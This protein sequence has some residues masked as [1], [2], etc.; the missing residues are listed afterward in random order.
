LNTRHAISL[1]AEQRSWL[2]ILIKFLGCLLQAVACSIEIGVRFQGKDDEISGLQWLNDDMQIL[3]AAAD[4]S[5]SL[6]QKLV[7]GVQVVQHDPL[8]GE[9]E[10]VGVIVQGTFELDGFAVVI[11]KSR[12]DGSIHR[13]QQFSE[14]GGVG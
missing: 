3:V 4:A 12:G 13:V 1:G 6:A 5:R 14:S 11:R 7:N 10:S 8:V 2:Q 9:M